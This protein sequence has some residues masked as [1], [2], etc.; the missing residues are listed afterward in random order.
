MGCDNIA[1]NILARRRVF[2]STLKRALFPP[3]RPPPFRVPFDAARCRRARLG[4]GRGESRCG[5]MH[6]RHH[7]S[8]SASQSDPPR[9]GSIRDKPARAVIIRSNLAGLP[10]WGALEAA[11]AA[12]SLCRGSATKVRI[13]GRMVLCPQ[14]NA[15]PIGHSFPIY[16]LAPGFSPPRKFAL[17]TARARLRRA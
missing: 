13:L 3:P 2:A 11:Q 8:L 4:A 12:S 1:R 7:H 6:L 10:R 17:S 15:C 5:L 16:P 9:A 14:I